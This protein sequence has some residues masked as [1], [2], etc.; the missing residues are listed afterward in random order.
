MRAAIIGSTKI[1]LIHYR[2]VIKKGY[3]EVYFISRNIKKAELFIKKNKLNN[4]IAKPGNIRLINNKKFQLI[5]ICTNTEY[6]HE[7]L[8]YIKKT[9]SLMIVE[10]PIFSIK[11]L[12]KNYKNFLD[13]IY[14]KFPNLIVCYPMIMLAKK[15]LSHSKSRKQIKN[16]KVYYKTGGKHT[17]EYIMQDLL[18]HALSLISIIIKKN[19]FV[20]GIKKIISK[21]NKKSWSARIEYEKIQLEFKFIQ[22]K[23]L[24]KSHFYFKINETKIMRPTKIIK[25]TFINYLSIKN[26]MIKIS[27]PMDDFLKKSL[28]IKKN[29][30][31]MDFNKKLTYSNMEL[32]FILNNSAMYRNIK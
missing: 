13:N 29:K 31:W 23:N 28:R 6:H 17:F 18:P 14:L 10:K 15:Y 32:N 1:A 9:N 11:K 2:S 12:K 3:D 16:I 7:Y 27:N 30:S 8:N 20:K 26:K 5:S 25:D 4:K 21:S 19:D 22:D 24:K